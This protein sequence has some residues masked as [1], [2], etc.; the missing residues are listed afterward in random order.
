[1]PVIVHETILAAPVE[2]VWLFFTDPVRNLPAISPPGDAVVIESADLPLKEGSV[3]EVATKDPFGRQVRWSSRI[4]VF[5]PPRP[6]VFGVEARLVDEQVSGPFARWRHE[7][8]FE[9]IDAKTTRLLDRVVYKPRHGV[10]GF[11]LDWL[12]IRWKIRGTLKY[13]DRALRKMLE[14]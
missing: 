4:T 13:R 9:A 2:R 1:M 5:T 6:V 7:H 14:K 3:I 11:I 8:E 10:A 12:I